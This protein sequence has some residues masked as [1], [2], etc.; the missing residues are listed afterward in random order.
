MNASIHIKNSQ[1]IRN[2]KLL[3]QPDR[4]HLQ[5]PVVNIIFNAE[6]VNMNCF[7][8]TRTRWEYPLSPFLFSDVQEVLA[9]A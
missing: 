8:K 6:I 1:Q 4:E 5:K 2:R 3:P 7:P 9:N